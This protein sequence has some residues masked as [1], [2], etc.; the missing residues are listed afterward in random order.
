MINYRKKYLHIYIWQA[1]SIIL[2][3]VSL[4]VVMPFL[5]SNKTLYGV[6]SVC[7]SLTIF[8]SYAD[9]G[10]LAAGTKYAAE[11]FIQGKKSEEIKIVGFTGFVMMAMFAILALIIVVMSIYPE[12]LIPEL[13]YGTDMYSIARSLLFTL[14][15]GCPLMIGQRIINLIFTIRVEDYKYQR[16]AVTGSIIKILSVFYFFSGG[17]YMLVQY[18][19]FFQV[20]NLLVV[21]IGI[22]FLR[23]YG[24][25]IMALI[26]AFR[27]DRDV[28][29]KMKNLS[30]TALILMMSAILF[31]EFDQLVVSHLL[32][33]EAVAIYGVALSVLTIVRTFS[34]FAFSPYASRYNHFAGLQDYVGLTEFT[35]KIIYLFV[36]IFVVLLF[37]F[38]LFAKPFVISWVGIDYEE[39][40]LLASIMVLG[41]I[42]NSVKDPITNYF[43]S[44][45]KNKILI[46]Y[47]VL[48]PLVYWLGI[49]LTVRRL[50]ILSFAILKAIAPFTPLI[51]YWYLARRDFNEKGTKFVSL[52]NLLK[53]LVMPTIVVLVFYYLVCPNLK[54]SQ[55]PVSLLQVAAVMGLCAV[56]AL[57][58]SIPLS[59]TYKIE[60]NRILDKIRKKY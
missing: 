14:A 41:F 42:A 43:V 22:L 31:Y 52:F 15:A 3:F 50:G 46:K 5:T 39:S 45:E 40:A 18:Y 27:F 9:L 49:I 36:P 2:G 20:V 6:Y 53:D 16:I 8:F 23:K 19:I 30:G 59:N 4:F 25:S 48:I 10:F 26:K 21:I 57:V 7:T 34:S 56:L 58:A 44:L 55:S 24:Y 47:N 60:L 54:V 17:R 33:I 28:F 13:I 37:T 35:K 38:S 51:G 11:Y 12:M 29:D 1:I 32:G